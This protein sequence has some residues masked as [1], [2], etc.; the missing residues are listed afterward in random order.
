MILESAQCHYSS[1]AFFAFSF[2]HPFLPE[3]CSPTSSHLHSSSVPGD[4]KSPSLLLWCRSYS[5]NLLQSISIRDTAL[6]APSF[7]FCSAI[8]QRSCHWRQ[9]AN[10]TFIFIII[11]FLVGVCYDIC[12]ETAIQW[13]KPMFKYIS[14]V[15]IFVYSSLFSANVCCFCCC[16]PLVF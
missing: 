7:T 4:S 10:N 8:H 12:E 6:H 15:L 5:F 16:Y 3:L 1:Q 14:T 11:F 9:R 13:E 2:C